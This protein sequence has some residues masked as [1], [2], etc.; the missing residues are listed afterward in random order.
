MLFEL[1]QHSGVG[2]RDG[3]LKD[4][5]PVQISVNE[6]KKLWG[7]KAHYD[8]ILSVGSGQAELAQSRPHQSSLFPRGYLTSL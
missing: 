1:L 8:L 7:E 5:N 2:C 3:G 6:S 4:K